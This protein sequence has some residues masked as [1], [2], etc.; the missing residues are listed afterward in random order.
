M[1]L[2]VINIIL[3]GSLILNCDC[4]LDKNKKLVV[5]YR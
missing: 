2:F 1:K 4:L 5:K 3:I